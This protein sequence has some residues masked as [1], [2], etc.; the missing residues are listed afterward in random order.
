MEFTDKQ[1]DGKF[2]IAE[3]EI[4]NEGEIIR[5][6][7]Y[8]PTENF[9]K[10]HPLIIYFHEFPQLFSFQ[11]VIKKYKYLLELG[12][13][14]LV[15]NFR[16][17]RLSEGKISLASQVS[18]GLKVCEFAKK[19]ADN[20]IFDI[21]DINIIANDLGAYIALL[22]ISRIDLINRLILLSPIIDLEN[23][24]YSDSFREV[25]EYVKRFLPT[26]VRG[27]GETEDFIELTKEE[28]SNKNLN[29]NQLDK[30][31]HF[32]ELKIIIGD[33]DKITSISEAR[34]FMKTQKNKIKLS[35]IQGMDHEPFAEKE[36][37]KV[38]EEVKF[39]FNK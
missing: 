39:F 32:K 33:N 14:F 37:E 19:M 20:A 10:P 34:N 31:L 6:I 29:I 22:V 21:N 12:Y 2:E 13:S 36:I 7:L 9:P 4:H 15:F 24:V 17:Y 25:L 35:I 5:G 23:H 3:I 27:I 30:N 38:R 26:N 1:Y 11:D 18:D 28:L 8:F 16:G